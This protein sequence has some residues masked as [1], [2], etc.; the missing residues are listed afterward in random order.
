MK[1]THDFQQLINIVKLI[2]IALITFS[3]R[4]CHTQFNVKID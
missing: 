2:I 3:D 4:I 1:I